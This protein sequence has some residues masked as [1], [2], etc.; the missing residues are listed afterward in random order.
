MQQKFQLKIACD[1]S[2][3]DKYRLDKYRLDPSRLDKR[4]RGDGV[5]GDGVSNDG[6]SLD[7]VSIVAREA[8][9]SQTEVKRAMQC[10]ALWHA[11][12]RGA[13][14]FKPRRIRRKNIALSEGDELY[15]N[16]DPVFLATRA[17]APVLVEDREKFSVW[18]KP[19]GVRVDGSKWGDHQS[20]RRMVELALTGRHTQLVHRLDQWTSGLV[21]LA[22]DKSTARQLSAL[23]AE[24]RVGKR[25]RALVAGRLE[26]SLPYIID[27][28]IDKKPSRTHILSQVPATSWL[29]AGPTVS[30][31][32]GIFELELKIDTGRTHQI[33]RHLASIGLPVVGDRRYGLEALHDARADLQL[34]AVELG[35]QWDAEDYR[36]RL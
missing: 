4:Q 27:A 14:R 13:R 26:Q 31:P 24:G 28:A 16:F 8:K 25:Y 9:L 17:A 3:L 15:F 10:G 22:H 12:Q 36:W 30:A 35:L 6:V 34:Q 20:L 21:L 11:G 2:V 19:A 7:V 32:N 5:G 23:F 33:R 29:N 1:A 18:N